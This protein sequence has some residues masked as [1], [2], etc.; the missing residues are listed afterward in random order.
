MKK[1]RVVET[2]PVAQV[3]H[4]PRDAYTRQLVDS[5]HVLDDALTTGELR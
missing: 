5:A 2:G 4:D 1:G 3:L